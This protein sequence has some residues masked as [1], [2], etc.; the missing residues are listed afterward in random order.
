MIPYYGRH[1]CKLHIRGKPIRFGF[2]TWVAAL[3]LGYCLHADL[4]QG[5]S[6]RVRTGLGQHVVRKLM[7]EIKAVYE[8]TN[9]SVYMDNFFT[10]LP[11]ITEMKER[12]VLV[13]G[14]VRNNRISVL[15]KMS[16]Y[17]SKNREVITIVGWIKKVIFVLYAGM[18]TVSWHC[19]RVST[20]WNLC[21]QQEGIQPRKRQ[22]WMCHNLTLYIN[23]IASW[24]VWIV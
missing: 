17:A 10:G 21:E 23:T 24:V 15:W 18:T 22:E 5:K 3:R 11:L 2:K 7:T 8:D 4:Y 6:E 14:T 13:T 20:A 1:G 16:S 9:F 19:Y 12:N